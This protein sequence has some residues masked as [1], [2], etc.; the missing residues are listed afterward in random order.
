MSNEL[1]EVKGERLYTKGEVKTRK[2][3]SGIG[4]FLVGA[5]AT[6]LAGVIVKKAINVNITDSVTKLADT[7]IDKLKK[8]PEGFKKKE[9]V[10]ETYP[11]D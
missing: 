1:E 2:T 5:A 6:L 10:K 4:G 9:E 11:E 7:G 3:A 8:I